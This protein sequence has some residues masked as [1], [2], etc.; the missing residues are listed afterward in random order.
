MFPKIDK[1]GTVKTNSL[2]EGK[3]ITGI[4][5]HGGVDIP[6][7]FF[8]KELEK[9][10]GLGP[11]NSDPHLSGVNSYHLDPSALL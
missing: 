3:H 5:A 4:P 7:S 8:L 10:F 1:W 9:L 11:A 2:E 6:N